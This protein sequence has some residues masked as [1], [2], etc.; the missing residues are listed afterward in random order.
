MCYRQLGGEG[1]IVVDV[2]GEPGVFDCRPGDGGCISATT[3]CM[4]L[5]GFRNKEDMERRGELGP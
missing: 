2:E 1:A 3:A 5:Q 4:A